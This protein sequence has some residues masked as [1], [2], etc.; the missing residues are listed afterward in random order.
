MNLKFIAI[1]LCFS[2]FFSAPSAMAKE[3]T[4]NFKNADIR[5]FIEFVAGFSGKNFLV[6]NRVKGKVTIVSPTPISEEHAYEVF[7]SVLEVNGFATVPGSSITKIVP[8]AE[9]KQ[10]ALPVRM[11]QGVGDDSM[12]TQVIKLRFADAQ[13]LVAL[14]RPLISPNSHLVAYPRGNM[15][16]L[17]D[18][19][20]NIQR[21]QRI[22]TLLDRKD[23]VGVQLF[24][25]KH[26]SA[27]KLA[28]TLTTL[29]AANTPG[30]QHGAV[31]AL[32]HQ[33]G[34]MLIVVAAPQIINEVAGVIERLDVAPESDSDRLQ[35]RYLKHANA[36][37]V[38]KVIN[39]LVGGQSAATA[40]PGQTKPL[41]SGDVK[42]VADASTNAL[43]ITADPSDIKAVS[44]IIDRLD[45]RRRQV[46]VEALIVEVSGNA[47]ERFGVEWM[48]TGGIGAGV[49]NFQ[50]IKPV[51][52]A[53]A[54]NAVAAAPTSTAT[55]LTAAAP[56]G[57]TL[58]VLNKALSIGALAQAMQSDVD[59]NVLSTPNLLTMDNEEAEIIVGKNVPFLTGQNSTQGGISNPFQ[60]IE[61]KDV[62]LT[63]R[64]KPQISEGDS[65][66]LEI[67]QE[68]SS[69]DGGTAAEGGLITSKRSIKTVVL[70]NDQQMI[71][72]GGLMRDDKTA[73]VQKVPCLGAV[74]LFGEPF[75]F[76]ENL[77][78]KTNLMVFLKPNIIVNASQ[79]EEITDHKYID[80]KKLYEQP[81][82]GGTIIFP[83]KEKQMPAELTP[84]ANNK[85]ATPATQ[86]Q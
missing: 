43:L 41:F 50:N 74:P 47:I 29:Y 83:K 15:L 77:T 44:R 21:I 84:N 6:D 70:A 4:L 80:I 51:G 14:I 26:A 49:Q 35:V 48:A 20:S 73:T 78:T 17:T 27:D 30:A 13:Q 9:S 64:V 12:V 1:A 67:Y 72:L 36:E 16:L 54:A 76:T 23:A 66:R 62:G 34:N 69:V 31:K 25:L 24:T 37:E 32:A 52:A 28:T 60:T 5:A 57:L 42:L 86:Q 56:T 33:P 71:V 68:I 38:A 39:E 55:A 61:R 7:L 11:S 85:S 53:L 58:G 81:L 18:S 82:Q 75:K 79:I 19:A 45:I 8:R 3:I 2:L 65:V 63:L 40:K 59:A 10:K 46:L 22:M